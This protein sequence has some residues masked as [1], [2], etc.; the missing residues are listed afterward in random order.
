ME[1]NFS[2]SNSGNLKM[3]E[4]GSAGRA[5]ILGFSIARKGKLWKLRE[6]KSEKAEKFSSH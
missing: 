2:D 6:N 4:S 1:L 5:S 3:K